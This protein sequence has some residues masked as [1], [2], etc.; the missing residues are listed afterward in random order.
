MTT[1]AN[2]WLRTAIYTGSNARALVPDLF[3]GL[4]AKR[5]LLLSDRGLEQ[6]GVVEKV[7][8]LFR[9]TTRGVGPELAGIFLDIR[10]DAESECVNEAVRYARE[11]GA[12]ALLAVGGGSVL[13]TAKGVKYALF[14]GLRDIKEAIPGGLLYESF[15][16]AQFM[17]IPHIAIPTTA[18]TGSEVS[19]IA[20]IYNE[21]LRLKTNII[22]PFINADVAVLDPDLTVGLPPKVTAFTGMDALTHAIEALASPTATAITDACALQAIRLIR[23]Y[24]PIA[25]RD[26]GNIRAR[27]E[28]LQASLLG[29]TAFSFALNA[30][31]V[32]NFAHAYGA[33]F[34]IPH[35]LANAVFLPVVMEA[36]PE[37]YLP[38]A[39]QLAEVLGIHDH[40]QGDDVLLAKSIEQIRQLRDDIGLPEDFADYPI[41]AEQFAATISAVASDPAAVSFPMPPELIRAIGERVVK[42]TVEKG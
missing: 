9:L 27:L 1:L 31:P 24:L 15:P 23:D 3:R 39:K 21:E 29:I 37:L 42:L 40:G 25:V 35:G 22:H 41:T 20:V 38:K 32:H 36:I 13:D 7:A 6:A 11:I 14:K 17:P 16:K 5:V 4:G 28:M 30:I 10:Q 12:D 34:R 8:E 26:G 2:F 33:M 18:G 19:P